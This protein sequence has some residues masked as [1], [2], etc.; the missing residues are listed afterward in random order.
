MVLVPWT[1]YSFAYDKL[2]HFQVT[3]RKEIF[4]IDLD[5]QLLTIFDCHP[6]DFHAAHALPRT[7]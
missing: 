5:V 1:A 7:P 3:Q 6:C 2:R 4:D